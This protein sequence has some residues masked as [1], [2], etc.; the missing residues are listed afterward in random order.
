MSTPR[1]G[2]HNYTSTLGKSSGHIYSPR[3]IERQSTARE[4]RQAEMAALGHHLLGQVGRLIPVLP[5]PLVASVLLD[6]GEQ[7][8]DEMQL[9]SVVAALVQ[10]LHA[11]DAHLYLPR[12]DWDYAVSAGLRMLTLRHL[13]EE[14]NGLY[15]ARRADATAELLRQL[16]GAFA[17]SRD[18]VENEHR[19]HAVTLRPKPVMAVDV[20]TTT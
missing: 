20:V 6:R 12:G 14:S 3:S 7:S 16:D 2:S 11:A 9:K 17:A 19:Q 13:V 5:L 15:R 8:T 1:F 18:D 4:Q 10:R